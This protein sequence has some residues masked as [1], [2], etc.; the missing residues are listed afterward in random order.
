MDSKKEKKGK[1][2]NNNENNNNNI[3]EKEIDFKDI[4]ALIN[5][6]LISN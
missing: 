6:N 4:D 2:R 5:C 1:K 3:D